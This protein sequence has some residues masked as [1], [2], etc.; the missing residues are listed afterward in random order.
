MLVDDSPAKNCQFFECQGTGSLFDGS[1]AR[2]F[3]EGLRSRV[4]VIDPNI[5]TTFSFGGRDAAWYQWG[6]QWH[7]SPPLD[8][9][10]WIA[11]MEISDIGLIGR[12]E[13]VANLPLARCQ[14]YG[15]SEDRFLNR[16]IISRRLDMVVT[17]AVDVY[18]GQYVAIKTVEVKSRFEDIMARRN[19]AEEIF[20]NL[21]HPHIIEFIQAEILKNEYKLVMEL[22]TGTLTDLAREEPYDRRAT[23][24]LIRPLLHQ[25]LQAL[26]YLA[27][28][29]I[30]HRDVKPDNILWRRCEGEVDLHYRLADFDVATLSSDDPIVAGTFSFMAPEV[31]L[32]AT[33]TGQPHTPKI[34]VWSLW[35]TLIWTFNM[36][37]TVAPGRFRQLLLES[38]PE[39]MIYREME[40]QAI[41]KEYGSAFEAMAAS[42]PK[43]RAS[44]GELLEW[45]FEGVG[46]ATPCP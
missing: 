20:T 6:I 24:P 43:E 7:V 23:D 46:R 22:Q 27:S 39:N 21:N 15:L 8:T 25:L 17:K 16:D 29:D 35:A 18:S 34:D 13:T 44:A 33:A 37:T 32:L 19:E 14:Y 42:D 4:A 38:F 9:F 11:T 45:M 31:S 30:I 5:N 36:G 3:R 40:T 41:A 10:E 2:Q 26:D 28:K 12:N 1:K